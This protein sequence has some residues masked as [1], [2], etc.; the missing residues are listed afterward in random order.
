MISSDADCS[1]A[2][3]TP[4]VMICWQF[5]ILRMLIQSFDLPYP[6]HPSLLED[7]DLQLKYSTQ[8]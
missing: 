8:A 1:I 4:S 3:I 5:R 6:D 7:V 2:A